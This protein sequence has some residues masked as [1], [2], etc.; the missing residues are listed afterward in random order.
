ML[1]HWRYIP[2]SDFSRVISIIHPVDL[3]FAIPGIPYKAEGN[4]VHQYCITC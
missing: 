4:S 1:K 3:V 2:Y